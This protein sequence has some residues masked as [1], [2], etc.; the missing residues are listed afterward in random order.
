V[1]VAR[2]FLA[3][4]G[5]VFVQRVADGEG[6]AKNVSAFAQ[7]RARL[8]RGDCIAIFPEGTTHDREALAPIRTGAARIAL[9]SVAAGAAGVTVVP[10]GMSYGDKTRLR[11]DVLVVGGPPIV[12]GDEGEDDHR[13]VRA[14][15]DRIASG[16]DALVPG[17]EDPLDAWALERAAAVAERSSAHEPD[18]VQRRSVA[19]QLARSPGPQRADV[20]DAAGSYSLALDLAGIDDAAVV[21]SDAPGIAELVVRAV[22]TW[23][24]APFIATIGLVNGPAIG[25]VVLVDRFVR[26]PVSKGTIRALVAVVVFPATWI[27]V[28]ALGADGWLAITALVLGHAIALLTALW[29]V[30]GDIAAALRWW[31]HYRARVAAARI[32]ALKARRVVLV[33]AVRD[34]R[35]ALDPGRAKVEP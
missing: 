2:P 10:V 8:R 31:R 23:L 15:T 16:L 20:L 12:V 3:L 19:R 26:T 30:E 9:G 35:A 5:V 24:L 28:A 22:V 1:L 7:C 11:N 25:A 27:T 34:A 29:L 33:R 21:G 4:A 32:P 13:A 17:L 18:L 6:T 14:L